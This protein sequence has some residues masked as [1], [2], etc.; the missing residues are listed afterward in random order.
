MEKIVIGLYEKTEYSE[1]FAEY[2]CHN[3]NNFIEFRIFTMCEK[4]VEY[5]EKKRIHILLTDRE[6]VDEVVN[7]RNLGKII[8][9]SEGDY[10]MENDKYP[11]IFKYQSVE[12]IIKEVLADIADDDSIG[13]TK[14]AFI[15]KNTE[16]IGVYSTSGGN[17]VLDY[18][19]NLAIKTGRVKKTLL[20]CLEQLNGLDGAL[21]SE[22]ENKQNYNRIKEKS[23]VRGMSEVIYYLNK[24]GNKL[25]LKLQSIICNINGVDCIYSVEDYRDFNFFSKEALDEMINVV[26]SQLGYETVIFV[27]GFLNETFIELMQ[28]C[29]KLYFKAAQNGIEHQRQKSFENMLKRDGLSGSLDNVVFYGEEDVNAV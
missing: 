10:V 23:Y 14:T 7:E 20:I 21:W 9:L 13:L 1:R 26:S 8:V 4:V 16:L 22:N 11:V 15:K 19:V 25:A 29:D 28:L 6:C 24:K 12:E 27:I 18:A 3:K 2:F 5:L 17:T